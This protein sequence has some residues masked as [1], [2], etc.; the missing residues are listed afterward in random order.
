MLSAEVVCLS[1]KVYCI[2]LYTIKLLSSGYFAAKFK[3]ADRF[4]KVIGAYQRRQVVKK[5]CFN[6]YIFRMAVIDDKTISLLN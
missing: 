1:I 3:A 5:C 2:H 4:Y 6:L